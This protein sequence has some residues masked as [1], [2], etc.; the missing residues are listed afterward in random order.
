[1]GERVIHLN[2]GGVYFATRADTLENSDSF[3]SGIVRSNP[4]VTELFVDRDPTHFRHIL[5][6]IRG[7]RHLPDDDSTLNEL[8][9]EADYYCLDQMRESITRCKNR[10]STARSLSQIH[11]ELKQMGRT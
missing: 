2:V 1:M 4:N 8:S 10:Y 9:W 5:N 11:S 7:V 6:W 3:F